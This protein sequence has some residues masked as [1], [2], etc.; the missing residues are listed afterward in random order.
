[1]EITECTREDRKEIFGGQELVQNSVVYC[2]KDLD[3]HEG[4]ALQC[5]H[6]DGSKTHTYYASKEQVHV[7]LCMYECTMYVYLC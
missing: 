2:R 1:M 6:R 5:V 7:C 4:F 3:R